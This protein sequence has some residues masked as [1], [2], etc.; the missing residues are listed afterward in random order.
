MLE[1]EREGVVLE[2]RKQKEK[3]PFESFGSSKIDG[4]RP[5]QR[6]TSSNGWTGPKGDRPT[7]RPIG[8]IFKTLG[9]TYKSNC[10]DDI[11][12]Y[13]SSLIYITY[14]QWHKSIIEFNSN[15]QDKSF[16]YVKDAHHD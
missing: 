4:S 14:I 11:H 3:N 12:L 1:E 15:Y 9:N 6:L 10:I 16:H 8:P 2:G 7:V 13:R 5:V